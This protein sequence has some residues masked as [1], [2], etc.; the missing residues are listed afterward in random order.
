MTNKGHIAYLMELGYRLCS[1]P[2]ACVS[3]CVDYH[4][5]LL[6]IAGMLSCYRGQGSKQQGRGTGRQ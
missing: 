2:R 5:A 1:W 6:S 4:L 3:A